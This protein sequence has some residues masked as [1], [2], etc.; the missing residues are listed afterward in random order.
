MKVV[1][2]NHAG[3]YGGPCRS[4]GLLIPHLQKL[5]VDPYIISPEGGASDFF[6]KFTPNVYTLKTKPLPLRLTIAKRKSMYLHFLRSYRKNPALNTIEQ[7]FREIKPDLVH[8]NEY[9]LI[10]VAK[11]A[12]KLDIPVVMHARTM[13]DKSHNFLNKIVLKGIKKYCAHLICISGSLHNFFTSV[14]EKSIVHNPYEVLP[15][16]KSNNN[17]NNN[18][19]KVFNFLSLAA[20]RKSKGIFELIEAAKILKKDPRVQ[21]DV[22]GSGTRFNIQDLTLKQKFVS[23]LGLA[24]YDEMNQVV[25]FIE[26]NNLKNINLLGHVDDINAILLKTDVILA[27]MRANSPPRSIYEAGVY[28]IPSIL[29]ME[30]KIEDVVEN[31]VSGFL[32]NEEAPEELAEAILKFVNDPDLKDKMGKQARIRCERNHNPVTNAQK[33]VDIY[34]KVLGK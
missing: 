13:P 10:S 23:Y 26:K 15:E 29:A 4:L 16:I 11:L 25:T 21:I 8:C 28:G 31:G 14:K 20:I 19:N 32:I 17:N 6:E 5:G 3:G 34:K 9:G 1:Y 30:D 33:L 24:N 12:A 22:A 18:N 27:P 2:I 7:L